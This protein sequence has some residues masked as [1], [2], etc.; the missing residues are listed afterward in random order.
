MTRSLCQLRRVPCVQ[1]AQAGRQGLHQDQKLRARRAWVPDQFCHSQL[2]QG[3][4]SHCSK[5][6]LHLRA[7]VGIKWGN[8]CR[9]LS[10]AHLKFSTVDG[11]KEKQQNKQTKNP[12]PI[13]LLLHLRNQLYSRVLVIPEKLWPPC[14]HFL[15][16][17]CGHF[18]SCLTISGGMRELRDTAQWPLMLWQWPHQAHSSKICHKK[19]WKSLTFPSSLNTSEVMLNT[20]KILIHF[21][22]SYYKNNANV[23]E[24][25]ASSEIYKEWE[26]HPS[27]YNVN[28][29]RKL[30]VNNL[31]TFP[32]SLFMLYIQFH[33]MFSSHDIYFTNLVFH[34]QN[35]FP[36]MAIF[37][38]F[39]I[40]SCL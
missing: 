28:H 39:P 27:I 35:I 18:L 9:L 8:T 30:N 11:F 36:I 34:A 31:N 38:L 24:H 4:T 16:K 7:H 22:L 32:A 14:E 23:P 40:F 21:S 15:L 19:R 12:N 1:E 2:T 29:L 17:N 10:M 25:L 37:R 5:P 33:Y 20:V 3:K 26:K 13:L 6:Q